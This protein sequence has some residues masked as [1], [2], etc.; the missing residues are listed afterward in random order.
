MAQQNGYGRYRSDSLY[1]IAGV[2]STTSYIAAQHSP[3]RPTHASENISGV[4]CSA[5]A[6]YASKSDSAQDS[7]AGFSLSN[8]P[9]V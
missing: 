7:T 5:S 1:M 3:R 8:E 4:S 9:A 6:R 2:N